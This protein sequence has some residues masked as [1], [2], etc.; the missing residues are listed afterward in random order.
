MTEPE[1]PTSE[2]STAAP[3]LGALVI[4]VAIVI[5]IWLFNVFS[6]DHLTEE[7]QVGRAAAA[8]NDALQRQDYADFRTYTCAAQSGE[9]AKV[10]ADQQASVAQ[11]GERFLDGVTDVGIDGD[12]ATA[13]VTYHFDKAPDAKQTV[14]MTFTRE[15]GAWKVCSTGPS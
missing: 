9:E 6:G 13:K 8:Q 1:E 5:A 4:I 3:F 10:I 11:H 15:D 7:Q 2:G 14:P 12:R